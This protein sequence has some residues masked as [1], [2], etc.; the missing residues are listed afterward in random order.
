M[1]VQWQEDLPGREPVR[2]LVRGV[3]GER[4]LADPG[5]PPDRV[6]A[7]HPARLRCRG[8]QLAQLSLPPGER[9]QV[10]G[11]RPGC[12]RGPARHGGISRQAPGGGRERPGRIRSQGGEYVFGWDSAAGRRDKQPPHRPG[13]A[14]CAGQ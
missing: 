11:Q 4:G 12:C 1:P 8:H 14:Q 6:N 5:H 3:H 7:D 9:G 13:Q 10:A 2:Q